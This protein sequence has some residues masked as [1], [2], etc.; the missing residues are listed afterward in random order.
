MQDYMM[1][2]SYLERADQVEAWT[3]P[4]K[5]KKLYDQYFEP[6]KQ[7][8]VKAGKQLDIELTD[9]PIYQ[10]VFD[11]LINLL[12]KR[13]LVYILELKMVNLLVLE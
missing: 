8:F 10:K 3:D 1:S 13:F 9:K 2:E 6:L 12:S 11:A 7:E 5:G 4:I